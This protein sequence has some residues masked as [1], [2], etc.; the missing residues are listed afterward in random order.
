M[1]TP[2]AS[3]METRYCCWFYYRCC[4]CCGARVYVCLY[5]NPKELNTPTVYAIPINTQPESMR[6]VYIWISTSVHIFQ[7]PSF[8]PLPMCALGSCVYRIATR[9]LWL[10][11][12]ASAS[13]KWIPFQLTLCLCIFLYGSVCVCLC[14]CA[15]EISQL[16]RAMK[17]RLFYTDIYVSF[18]L[19]PNTLLF[20]YLWWICS[21]LHVRFDRIGYQSNGYKRKSLHE[22]THNGISNWKLIGHLL[23]INRLFE[24]MSCKTCILWSVKRTEAVVGSCLVT[25]LIHGTVENTRTRIYIHAIS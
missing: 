17:C 12:C 9:H 15:V 6:T 25:A 2:N 14:V 4:C 5:R 19:L 1:H 11:S 16:L 8:F 24:K 10:C 21:V 22:P 18:I 3:C 20:N 23:S 13:C 7:F